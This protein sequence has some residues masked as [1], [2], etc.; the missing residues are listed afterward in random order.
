M[1]RLKHHWFLALAVILLIAAFL[2]LTLQK[3][4]LREQHY[5]KQQI[6]ELSL[7]ND[8]LQQV[9]DSQEQIIEKLTTDSFYLEFIARTKFGM[10]KK[11]ETGYQF[12]QLKK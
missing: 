7:H 2:H 1:S 12:I 11:G 6:A 4:G 9:L 5:L 8:S 3:G 10:M